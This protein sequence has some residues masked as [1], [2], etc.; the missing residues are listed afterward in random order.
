MYSKTHQIALLKIFPWQ[1][2]PCRFD[3]VRSNTCTTYII[4]IEKKQTIIL[5]LFRQNFSKIDSRT[6][7]FFF[8]KTCNWEALTTLTTCGPDTP[9][10]YFFS[11]YLHSKIVITGATNSALLNMI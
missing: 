11:S 7:Y 2:L 1:L 5:E 3:T 8:I 9:L 10:L 4:F 6:H